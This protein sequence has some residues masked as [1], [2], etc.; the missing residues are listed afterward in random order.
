MPFRISRDGRGRNA[1][2]PSCLEPAYP[3]CD[4]ASVN[5]IVSEAAA[6]VTPQTSCRSC[7]AAFYGTRRSRWRPTS[8]TQA[9]AGARSQAV[10]APKPP[11]APV[12]R[13]T[14]PS[15]PIRSWVFMSFAPAVER[16]IEADPPRP[17]HTAPLANGLLEGNRMIERTEHSGQALKD[18]EPGR[19]LQNRYDRRQHGEHGRWTMGALVAV[20]LGV[21]LAYWT[22]ACAGARP[23]LDHHV[24]SSFAHPAWL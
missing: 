5:T 12:L 9:P 21:A 20:E 22:L 18:G 15:S 14:L 8:A 17:F 3:A 11:E 13:A 7:E 19:R 24:Y 6:V 10:A 1:Q 4:S 2:L 16:S 23:W